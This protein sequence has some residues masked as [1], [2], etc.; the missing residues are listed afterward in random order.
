MIELGNIV[1]GYKIAAAIPRPFNPGSDTV[2][3]R[4]TPEGNCMGGVIYDDY[5]GNCIFM[6]QA[7][8]HK[9][10][11]TG[12]MMWIVFDYPFNKLGVAKVGGTINSNNKELL[13]FNLRL[14]FKEEARIKNAYSNGGDL[15]ILTM[16]RAAC[17][18]LKIKPKVYKDITV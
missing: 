11:L 4:V 16:E 9:N 5:T 6:H 1:H 14:G 10:W 17:R 2:I 3:S 15:I 7:S 18:W 8:F 13:D 12:N